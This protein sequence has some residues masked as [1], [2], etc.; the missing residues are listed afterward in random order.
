MK[1][2]LR[3]ANWLPTPSFSTRN[4]DG[5]HVGPYALVITDD[6]ETFEVSVENDVNHDEPLLVLSAEEDVFGDWVIKVTG[7]HLPDGAE[8]WGHIEQIVEESEEIVDL[9]Q[10]L[11]EQEQ[12]RFRGRFVECRHC[13]CAPC[14]CDYF[15]DSWRD[16]GRA[17]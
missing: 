14:A 8:E 10:T 4:T 6:G 2:K 13:E 17:A 3:P 11:I 16:E 9:L 5:W 12:A 15:Y 7:L 1:K